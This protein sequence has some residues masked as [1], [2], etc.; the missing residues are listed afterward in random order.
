MLY[1]VLENTERIKS[2]DQGKRTVPVRVGIGKT[3]LVPLTENAV[4]NNETRL[5][6]KKN[7]RPYDH[8][9]GPT[10][11]GLQT[12]HSVHTRKIEKIIKIEK[13]LERL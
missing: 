7:I 3:E 8:R 1:F 9:D 13:V 4:K 2:F 5:H 10:T 6:Y 11:N 12:A